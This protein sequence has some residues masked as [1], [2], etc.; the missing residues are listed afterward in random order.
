[1]QIQTC[2]RWQYG[3]CALYVYAGYLF[4]FSSI[5][6]ICPRTFS[7]HV[8]RS[9]LMA[10]RKYIQW[11][12]SVTIDWVWFLILGVSRSHQRRTTVGRTLLDEWPARRRDL[13]L[14][15]L[16]TDRHPCPG[17]IRTHNPS[18]R[19][20]IDL[21]LRPRGHWDWHAGYLSLL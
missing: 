7:S 12:I 10:C 9:L 5:I 20:A 8:W 14:T 6:A 17:G 21:R 2:N 11:Y 18:R 19:V 16:T 3:A 15:T 1:M 4:L 13:Y